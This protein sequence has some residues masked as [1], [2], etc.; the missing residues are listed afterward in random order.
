[1]ADLSIDQKKFQRA[2]LSSDTV[3]FPAST[4]SNKDFRLIQFLKHFCSYPESFVSV[5]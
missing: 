3:N 2:F 4:V 1:M 5:L